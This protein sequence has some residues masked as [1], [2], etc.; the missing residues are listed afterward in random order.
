MLRQGHIG[1][2]LVLSSAVVYAAG[3]MDMLFVGI[4]FCSVLIFTEGLPDLDTSVPFVTHRGI[5][6]TLWFAIAVSIISGVIGGGT[7]LYL[8]ETAIWE[9]IPVEVSPLTVGIVTGLGGGLGIISHLLGDLITPWGIEPFVPLSDRKVRV[10]L[11]TA[12]N[13][14][15]NAAV[16]LS[17]VVLSGAALVVSSG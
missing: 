3:K 9:S 7:V 5:T 13:T 11:T 16:F 6:H 10:K 4:Y 12:S 1:V 15:V 8:A 17:G 2:S 14:T